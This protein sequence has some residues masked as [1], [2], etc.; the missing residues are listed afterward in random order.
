MGLKSQKG[1][2]IVTI[3][4]LKTDEV[5]KFIVYKEVGRFFKVDHK[6]IYNVANRSSNIYKNRWII[7]LHLAKSFED[8]D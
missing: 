1:V 8:L 4:D 7:T 6:I 2:N 3:K 5:F